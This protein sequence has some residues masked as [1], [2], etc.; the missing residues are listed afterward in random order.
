M[1]VIREQV[2]SLCVRHATIFYP[3]ECNSF[4]S[5]HENTNSCTLH[6]FN[7]HVNE[8]RI[9][10]YSTKR[11]CQKYSKKRNNYRDYRVS[12]S[13]R[14]IRA[15]GQNNPGN[16][17]YCFVKQTKYEK[18]DPEISSKHPKICLSYKKISTPS[19]HWR[20]WFSNIMAIE[21]IKAILVNSTAVT[22]PN[23]HY[24]WKFLHHSKTKTESSTIVRVIIHNTK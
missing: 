21:P 23:L 11:E 1:H 3:P 10:P 4:Q 14:A 6:L 20:G 8:H 19:A 15:Y 18:S 2:D 7:L 17:I 5:W 12:V 9:Y 22:R 24:S 13:H 16:I